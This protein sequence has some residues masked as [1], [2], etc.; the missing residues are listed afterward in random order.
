M[1][2]HDA[3]QMGTPGG[4]QPVDPEQLLAGVEDELGRLDE[5]DTADQVGVY[6]RAHTALAEALARTADTAGPALGGR[7]GA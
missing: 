4:N 6:D 3:R 1:S 7:P 2:Q 5:V